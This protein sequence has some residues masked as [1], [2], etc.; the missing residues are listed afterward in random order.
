MKY[1]KKQILKIECTM[2]GSEVIMFNKGGSHTIRIK[3][4]FDPDGGD[5]RYEINWDDYD[6]IE[7]SV[8]IASD[9]R[10]T[11][12]WITGESSAHKERVKQEF[13]EES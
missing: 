7:F 3:K 12:D 11:F 5:T 8:Q 1:E 6:E 9:S 10:D 2:N 13:S 4:K